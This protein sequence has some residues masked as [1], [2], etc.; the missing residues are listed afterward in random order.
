M[1]KQRSVSK[2]WMGKPTIEGAGVRLRR[3][4]GFY[5]VPNLDPFLLLDH[6]GSDNPAD[7]LAGFPY[8]PHRGIETI[9][10]MMRGRVEHQD[11]LGNK[12][13]IESGDVQWMTAGSGIIHQE[14]PTPVEGTMIGFQLWANLPASHKMMNPRYRDVSKESIP[15]VNLGGGVKAKVVAGAIADIRGPVQDVVTKPQYIDVH[16]PPASKFTHEIEP[17]HTA[18]AY[19]FEGQGLFDSSG[20]SLASAGNLV[21]YDDEGFVSICSKKSAVRF[22]LVSGKPIEEPIAWRGPIVMNTD[23]EL[24][25][26]FNEYRNGTFLKHGGMR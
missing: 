1:E 8:H 14:M 17:G 24:R 25:I 7:Y 10:Y 15:E 16:I 20:N 19:V 5:E 13:V 2:V 3:I 4:F 22:L 9:T 6:F 23:E 12:G 26:A 21:L 18:F 11:S